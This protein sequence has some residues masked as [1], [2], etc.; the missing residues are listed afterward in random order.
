[1][2]ANNYVQTI[3]QKNGQKLDVRIAVH[4]GQ[5]ISGIFGEVKPQF[6][7]VGHVVRKVCWM[8]H[9]AQPLMVI[10]SK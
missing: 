6:C 3:I 2:A 9:N 1:M 7:I 10:V 8:C 4:T 5:V